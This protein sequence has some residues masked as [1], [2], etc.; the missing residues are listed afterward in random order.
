MFFFAIDASSANKPE[1][2]GVEWYAFHLIQQLKKHA[3]AADEQVILY[4]PTPLSAPLSD[5][6]P[7]WQ[8]RVL[9]WRLPAG[10]M[11]GRVAWE[12]FRR[13][14]NVFFVPSQGL[15][16][17]FPHDAK[18][19]HATATTLHDIGFR[20]IPGAYSASMRRELESLTR[21]AVKRA[22]KILT[23]SA[24]SKQE[25]MDAYR[26][27]ED[28]I[29]VTPL[30]A[31]PAFYHPG[32]EAADAGILEK[33]RL[34][35][36]FFLYVG[37]LEQKKNSAILIRAFDEFKQRRGVGDPFE[38]VL[39]GPHGYGFE[40]IK[41]LYDASPFKNQIRNLGYIP[42]DEVAALMRAARAFLFPSWYEGFGIPLLEAMACGTPVIASDIPA[43]RE[44]A[45]D[46]AQFVPPGD[47]EAWVSM[48]EKTAFQAADREA[49][50]QKGFARAAMFTWE[51][52][53][54][55]TWEALRGMV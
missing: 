51:K 40:E 46:A 19:H 13:P 34:G 45:A 50:K 41:A 36:Q 6:P 48:L 18:T 5:L 26:L 11:Q 38:L 35:K 4:S 31:D 12:L 33:H 32:L 29:V 47:V 20:R 7:Q 8:S 10:W 54:N 27:P 52:T 21:R 3:L 55:A 23:V 1:R 15:P 28:R 30:A 24:F 16:I 53:A 25:L 42:T 22:T 2:T 44:V 39:A 37:R 49:M 17:V 9:D 14:P 43:H